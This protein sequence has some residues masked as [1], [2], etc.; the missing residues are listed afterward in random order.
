MWRW[1]GWGFGCHVVGDP[2]GFAD[3]WSPDDAP[4]GWVVLGFPGSRAL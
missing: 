4:W 2:G 1:V 3:G